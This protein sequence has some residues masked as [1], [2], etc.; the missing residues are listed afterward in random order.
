[1]E[2]DSALPPAITIVENDCQLYSSLN[3][4]II[5]DANLSENIKQ[6]ISYF[7][8][9][10]KYQPDTIWSSMLINMMSTPKINELVY[11]TLIDNNRLEYYKIL[12]NEF[13][14]ESGYRG[15]DGYNRGYIMYYIPSQMN[16]FFGLRLSTYIRRGIFNWKE[17]NY[18]SVEQR[19]ITKNCQLEN[20]EEFLNLEINQL[21][22]WEKENLTKIPCFRHH[23]NVIKTTDKGDGDI[24]YYVDGSL[25]SDI[26]EYL[27]EYCDFDDP[28]NHEPFSENPNI[29]MC[30]HIECR[31]EWRFFFAKLKHSYFRKIGNVIVSYRYEDGDIIRFLNNHFETLRNEILTIGDIINYTLPNS[32]YL[33]NKTYYNSDEKIYDEI[34]NYER[35]ISV[36]RNEQ[37]TEILILDENHDSM[38]CIMYLIKT[39]KGNFFTVLIKYSF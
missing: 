20:F 8:H 31:T 23:Q 32:E 39:V 15:E 10:G 22:W 17:T 34:Y 6:A 2:L 21:D 4:H 9:G 37:I 28:E 19:E 24:V 33:S 11:P 26:S 7:S 14:L 16:N 36:D 35:L 5:G 3:E 1:M 12:H 29:I 27:R 13:R 30:D 18:E 38:D 25:K